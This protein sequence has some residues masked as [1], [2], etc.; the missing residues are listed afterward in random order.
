MAKELLFLGGR[1]KVNGLP[2]GD[3][4]I[5]IAMH[6][7]IEN[8]LPY[9]SIPAAAPSDLNSVLTTGNNT[10][11]NDII[12]KDGQVLKSDG[13]GA[14]TIDLDSWNIFLSTDGQGWSESYIYMTEQTLS[15][16][17][18]DA[19]SLTFQGG[20]G[21]KPVTLAH[22]PST[23]QLRLDGSNVTLTGPGAGALIVPVAATKAVTLPNALGT[24]LVTDVVEIIATPATA[25]D[26]QTLLVDTT[27]AGGAVVVNLPVITGNQRITV[28]NIAGANTI[29][30]NPDGSEEIDGTPTSH[31]ILGT[32]NNFI[33]VESN[34]TYGWAVVAERNV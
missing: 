29:S 32:V 12:L 18:Q 33:T 11:A 22:G 14:N 24:V 23:S 21:A 15:M 6:D 34:T 16:A 5:P 19:H 4:S 3:Q 7:Y 9:I 1:T 8:L 27:T 30:L 25:L 2:N 13:G 31:V 26:G 20:G 10:G 28:K 17:S